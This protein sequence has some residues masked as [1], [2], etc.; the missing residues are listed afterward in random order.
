[1]LEI[2]GL[3]IF[4]I[5]FVYIQSRLQFP[6]PLDSTEVIIP[7]LTSSRGVPRNSMGRGGKLSWTN[8]F[9]NNRS[10]WSGKQVGPGA[11]PLTGIHG[12]KPWKLLGCRPFKFC[13][14]ANFSYIFHIHSSTMVLNW[15]K[16]HFPSIRQ[17]N[18]GHRFTCSLFFFY[19]LWWI[20]ILGVHGLSPLKLHH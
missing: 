2:G 11:K 14:R 18:T 13:G 8:N 4:T 10:E 6:V 19:W 20:S 7:K 16:N 15:W 9:T 1:M 12:S 17:T 5:L 3:R